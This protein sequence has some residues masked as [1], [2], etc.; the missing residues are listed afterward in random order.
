[1]Q[2]ELIKQ[3]SKPFL[4]IFVVTMLLLIAFSIANIKE[5][6]ELDQARVQLSDIGFNLLGYVN[7]EDRQFFVK[8]QNVTKLNQFLKKHQLDSYSENIAYIQNINTSEIMWHSHLD[9]QINSLPSNKD[10]NL[11]LPLPINVEPGNSSIKK[12]RVKNKAFTT[13]VYAFHFDEQ[14][15]YQVVIAKES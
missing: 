10:V 14:A 3:P 7:Y 9:K 11:L 6:R 4:I 8:Q 15:R 5:N 12:H 13:Y 2:N 1:M